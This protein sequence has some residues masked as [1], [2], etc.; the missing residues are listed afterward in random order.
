MTTYSMSVNCPSC[1]SDVDLLNT[2]TNMLLMVAVVD[3]HHCSKEWEI[4][5][6]MSNHGPSAAALERTAELR[7]EWKRSNPTT[8]RQPVPA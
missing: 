5:A 7:R 4:T 8:P 3:C 2:R 1:G 6:R